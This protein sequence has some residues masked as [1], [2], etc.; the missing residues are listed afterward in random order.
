MDARTRKIV[1]KN[2]MR[3]LARLDMER[4]IVKE[5]ISVLE[6]EIEEDEKK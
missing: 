6:K 4:D 2:K 3:K 1:C 5:E